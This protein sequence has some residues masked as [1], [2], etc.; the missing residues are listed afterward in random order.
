MEC[1]GGVDAGSTYI[2]AAIVDSNGG[3]QGYKVVPTGIDFRSTARE[4]FGELCDELGL[5]LSDIPAVISTGYGRR[6]IDIAGEDVTEIKAHAA[7]GIRTAPDGRRIGT[8]ID[9]GGQDSKVIIIDE[10]GE[11]KNFAMNDKCAAGTGRF[12][13]VISRVL[14]VDVEELGPLSLQA[15]VPCRINS[16]CAV[17]AESE[18]ISLLARG[19]DRADI[20]AGI[21]MSLARRISGMARKTGVES[22]VLLTGGGALNPGL[23]AAFEDELMMDIYVAENPQ[24]N[25]AIGAAF[26]GRDSNGEKG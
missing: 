5:S 7:G 2:K 17:F 25:G 14:K 4:V 3:V 12:L 9:I 13:E 24:L 10:D 22:D 26:L 8:I 15:K 19:K 18:V 23:V 20:I 6:L 1:Y 16:L 11:T 21:H